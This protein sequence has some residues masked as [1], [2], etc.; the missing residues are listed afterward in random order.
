MFSLTILGQPRT[1][2]ET[3][4]P[5]RVA[6]RTFEQRNPAIALALS[7]NPG[8]RLATHTGMPVSATT[9]LRLIREAP[10]D[11]LPPIR[12]LGVDD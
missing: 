10:P 8:A 1:Q 6:L 2:P 5:A 4:G 12:V 7:G 9:L 3:A 11:P